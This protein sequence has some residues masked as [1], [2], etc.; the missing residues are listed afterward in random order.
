MNPRRAK[1]RTS[2]KSKDKVC[3]IIL[4][5]FYDTY[6]AARSLK[7]ARVKI[8]VIKKGLKQL[9]LTEKEIISNLHY[10]IQ[11]D[12]IIKETESYQ[13]RTKRGI[14]NTRSEFYEISDKG[15]DH[16]DGV[17]RF[18][19]TH[20][21]SGINITNIQGVTIVGDGNIVNDKYSDLY[22][23]LGLLSEEV[24]MSD[25]FSDEQKLNYHAEINTIKSQLSKT[26]PDKIIIAKAWNTLKQLATVAGIVGFFERVRV[27]IE[28]L[29]KSL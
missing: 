23:N 5:F 28:L 9:G 12:W 25:K 8:S 22:G 11:T 20:P 15:V 16:F 10:L 1:T 2:P 24:M 19:K 14:I 21:P 6:K 13:I 26:L 18:Q 7:R 3:E 4:R 29:L 27:L 17:S